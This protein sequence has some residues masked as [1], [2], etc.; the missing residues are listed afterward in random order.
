MK[1]LYILFII[2]TSANF[3][4]LA[5]APVDTTLK[6]V[7]LRETVIS[8]NR[9]S[10]ARSAVAQQVVILP[11]AEIEQANAQTTADLLQNTGTVFVQKSQQ[12]G[13]SPVIRGFEAS[14]VL[15]V[16]D[17]V[18]MNNAIYR[19]GHLQ[20]I[21]TMENAVL[22]LVEVLYGPASTVYGTD[23]L[24]GAICFYTK[25][26][27]FAAAGA[28]LKTTGNG[29]SRYSTVNEEKTGHA[30]VSV[31]GE[32]WGSLTSFT[33]SDFGDLRMG[34]QNGFGSFF[35][36]RN[37]YAERINGQDSL[38]KNTDPYV[39]KFSGYRQ[40]DLLEKIVYRPNANSS[41]TL[42]VQWSNSTDIPRYDRLTNPGSGGRGLN[43]AEWYY[44][45]QKRLLA[46][47]TFGVAQ[48]GWFNGGLQATAS[49]Q[50]IE[51]SR[52]SRGFGKN[53]L[54]SR[55]EQV[56]VAGLT[57]NAQ[58]NWGLQSLSLGV[59]GQYNDVTSTAIS[60]NVKTGEVSAASTRYPDGGSQMTNA[61]VY[62]TH[63]WQGQ[64]NS[65]WTFS[66]GLRV[67]FSSL[68]A[69]FEDKTFF[70]FPFASIEQRNPM[71]SGN[72]GAVW[73]G[74]AGWRVAFN[75][76]TGFRTP[77]VDDLAKVFDSQSGVLLV[78]P[79]PD[80][81]PEKTFNFDM[82]VTR[83][84]NDRMRWE[85]VLWVTAF[86]D[87]IVTDL[88]QF[89]GQDFVE[90][91]GKLTR[92]AAPQ[93]KR[94]A[95]LWGFQSSINADVYTDLALYASVAYTHG[96]IQGEE[97]KE[98]TPLDHIPPV[99]GRV[100]FR[101]HTTKATVEGFAL[102]NGTKKLADYNLEG[103][104]NLQYAPADGMPGWLTLNLRGGYRFNRFLN[105]QAGL[106]NI[107]DTQYRTFGSGINAP[108]RNLFVALRVGF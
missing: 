70:K 58:R 33:F 41:H 2:S 53:G 13:G 91:D 39:Q 9:V 45:P 99:Y 16:V 102:F 61:A 83:Q 56:A 71:A 20:N 47:Y 31:A 84:V 75:G 12:G 50:D 1:K 52:H 10:Q 6:A 32:K 5:Q 17:G 57:I 42:N 64:T 25:N 49:Y 72:I 30:D 78:V 104:D 101:W 69:T 98:D 96:R 60:T 22:D 8:A 29:F 106:E 15:L 66:E 65:E 55:T 86:R 89:N 88:F 34:E 80:L 94:T 28:G 73:N 18:R 67:G 54:T 36:K 59:D 90:Y 103:E 51:E 85:N 107:L 105:V 97:G 82:N 76:S 3:T 68:S 24:G 19:A 77:N 48:A 62:A 37:V 81:K 14:R 11:K 21:I 74:R 46:A 108:G 44:G 100:G 43:S 27:T 95:N 63:H 93:N 38:V 40:S 26:P 87:A 79:N 23:A 4:A 7:P 92:V 35:G